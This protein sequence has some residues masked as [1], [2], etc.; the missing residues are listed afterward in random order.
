MDLTKNHQVYAF[1]YLDDGIFKE[2]CLFISKKKLDSYVKIRIFGKDGKK[3][4]KKK[5]STQ[6][7]S[8][9]P[10]FNEEIVFTNLKKDQL[11]DL[12]INFTIYHDSM[13]NKE[14]LGYVDIS[15]V[16]K[17]NEYIQW[18]DM[19]AGKKSIAWWHTLVSIPSTNSDSDHSTII[20]GSSKTFSLVNKNSSSN[21]HS[22]NSTS[23]SN[24]N[25][26]NMAKFNLK[27]LS[28]L[29]NR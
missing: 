22:N 10:I 1:I 18:R 4:K 15:A 9:I 3:L 23:N 16:S 11:N 12:T 7:S 21:L 26:I 25:T 24:K 27:S 19:I 29:N 28:L 2:I 8:T 14:A 6:K 17:G 13:T 5:T 20:E